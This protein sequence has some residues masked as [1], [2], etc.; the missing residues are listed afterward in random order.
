MAAGHRVQQRERVVG[1]AERTAPLHRGV[2][3][4]AE[5]EDIRRRCRDLPASNLRCKV[6]RGTGHHPGLGH[7]DVT[8]GARDRVDLEHAIK[9]SEVDRHRSLVAVA[10]P[11]LDPAHHA[12]PAAEGDG[13]GAGVGTPGQHRLHLVLVPWPGHDIRR[14]VDAT[15]EGA[16]QVPVA[17]PV[18]VRDPLLQ[19]GRGDLGQARRG[20]QPGRGQVD[21]LEGH[22]R[23]HLGGLESQVPP[24][25]G[26][27]LAHLG[28]RRLLI[29][30]AP[31]PE[32]EPPL[33]R[34][35]HPRELRRRKHRSESEGLWLV[36]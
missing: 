25:A 16:D 9:R 6:G 36:Q 2:K 13:R 4:G 8:R 28:R 19:R 18:G 27:G 23:L 30:V 10:D 17:L 31:P 1:V 5:G 24:D 11:R 3:R 22:R 20:R 12:R 32:L 21:R 34:D 26:G 7:R 33:G 15:L 14:V 35:R 29:L